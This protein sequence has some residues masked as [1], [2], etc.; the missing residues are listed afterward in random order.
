MHR[1]IVVLAFLIAYLVP[2]SALANEVPAPARADAEAL[3]EKRAESLAKK[4]A[5]RALTQGRRA[6][7]LGPQIGAAPTYTFDGDAGFRGSFGLSLLY[8]DVMILPGIN[9]LKSIVMDA[10]TDHFL[11][12]VKASIVS[13]R[14][15]TEEE[16]G[17]IAERVWNDIVA[18]FTLR[19]K[20]KRFEK[21]KLAARLAV[22]RNT[23]ES[24]SAW[25]VGFTLG[26]GIGPVYFS[27]GESVQV[28]KGT[29][30]D[31]DV[32]LALPM[33]LSRGL[34]S[35]TVEFFL[36][37]SIANTKRETRPDSAMLG[38]R[39]MLDII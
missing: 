16:K 11:S 29:G 32:E 31:T 22:S 35:P 33:T 9:T 4:I 3:F 23:I 1:L 28:N 30:L 18:K 13:G 17:A 10:A 12:E 38:A 20:P 14:S 24:R 36:R 39:V 37:A 5:K 19:Q 21:P 7:V 34:R 8:F 25:G 6:I 27:A 26:I 15:L 2:N